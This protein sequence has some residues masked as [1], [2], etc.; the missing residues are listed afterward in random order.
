MCRTS[1]S[2]V[3]SP[4][5]GKVRTYTRMEGKSTEGVVT[6]QHIDYGIPFIVSGP[7]YD[8]PLEQL[9]TH[10]TVKTIL[11]AITPEEH[12]FALSSQI[13]LICENT[14]VK[15]QTNDFDEC[16]I[17]KQFLLGKQNEARC[18]KSELVII[19]HLVLWSIKYKE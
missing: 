17:L 3:I 19:C 12:K 16:C 2:C 7:I 9:Q 11:Q 6:L 8:T 5:Y 13:V 10:I 15:F 14:T 18:S 1:N 4:R